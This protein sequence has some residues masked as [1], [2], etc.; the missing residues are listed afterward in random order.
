M[1]FTGSPNVEINEIYN[2]EINDDFSLYN[3]EES[4]PFITPGILES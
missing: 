3:L 1:S 4:N 2:N